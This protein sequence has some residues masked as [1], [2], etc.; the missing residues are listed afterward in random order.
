M[1]ETL[2]RD[3]QDKFQSKTTAELLS[4]WE[5]ESRDEYSDEA[6]E[7]VRRILKTQGYSLPPKKSSDAL[8]LEMMEFPTGPQGNRYVCTECQSTFDLQVPR[9]ASLLGFE[10][11]WCPHCGHRFRYPLFKGARIAWIVV[12]VCGLCA[13]ANAFQ[14]GFIVIPGL[15]WSA[16]V[17][18]LASDAVLRR[19]VRRTWCKIHMSN[20]GPENLQDNPPSQ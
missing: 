1:N 7:A 3:I 6:F 5:K 10:R 4:I 18:A 12:F 15:L 9:Y 13:S 19:K 8:E 14:T 16:S 20:Q 17:G 11:I 2:I